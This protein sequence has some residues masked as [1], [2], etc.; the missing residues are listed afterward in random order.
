LLDRLA[1]LN[2]ISS[3]PPD[4]S[5]DRFDAGAVSRYSICPLHRLNGESLLRSFAMPDPTPAPGSVPMPT[6]GPVPPA[7]APVTPPVPAKPP[8]PAT[9]IVSFGDFKKMDLR[10]AKILSAEDHPNANKLIVMKV[11]IGGGETR[12]IVAGLK[13]HYAAASLAGKSVAMICNLQPAMLRGVESQGMLLAASG[14][15]TV[16]LLT[17]EKDLPPGSKI[18]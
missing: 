10:I 5:R 11:D 3:Q 14:A 12:Q 4:P 15:E 6:P 8:A 18:S 7:A 17:L 13:P 16:V 9:P 2:G 1:F